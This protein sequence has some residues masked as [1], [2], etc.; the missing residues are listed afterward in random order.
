MPIAANPAT[1]PDLLAW[2]N[3]LGNPEISAT[4]S[5]RGQTPPPLASA[6]HPSTTPAQPAT[7]QPKTRHKLLWASLAAVVAIA[8]VIASI[9]IYRQITGPHPATRVDATITVGNDPTTPVI[10][11]DGTIYV[12]NY[13]DDYPATDNG[14]VSVIKNGQV[15]NTITVGQ[16]PFNPVIATDGTIYVPNYGDG[17]VSVLR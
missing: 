6:T 12:A 10:A 13:G 4:I 14:T 7:T 3:A 2:L 9:V 17:T 1:Q 5:R 16:F 8:V 11:A 15:T